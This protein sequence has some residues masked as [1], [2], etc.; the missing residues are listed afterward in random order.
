VSLIEI[1]HEVEKLKPEDRRHLIAYL[2]SLEGIQD[3]SLRA[4]LTR[5]IDDRNP[6]HW[7]SLEEARARLGD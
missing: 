5:K 6:E 3:S 1:K 4:E 7:I 2:V